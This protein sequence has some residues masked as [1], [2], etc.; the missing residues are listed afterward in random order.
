[1]T[2]TPGTRLGPYEVLS[3]L[4]AGGMGEVWKAKDTRL[5]RFVAIKVLP[6][7]LAKHPESLAR[8]EREAKAVAALNHPNILALHDIGRTDDTAY[9]VME[10]LEG[11]NLRDRLT[12]GPLPPRKATELAVQMA[13]G[14]AAAHE[15]GIVHRDL[16]PENLWVTRDGRLKIL[17]FGL[18]KQGPVLV[19]GGQTETPTQDF[20]HATEGGTVLGTVGYMSPEQVRGEAADNRSDIFSFGVVLFE[21]LGGARP[22]K[23]DT[24]VQTM[25]AILEDDPPELKLAKGRLPPMLGRIIQHCLEKAPSERF[26]SARDLAFDL[27]AAMVTD[28]ASVPPLVKP[29]ILGIT[30]PRLSV[31]ICFCALLGTGAWWM[32]RSNAATPVIKRLT[33]GKGTLGAARFVPGSRDVVYSARWNGA[34]PELFSLNPESLE[35]RTLG[36]KRASLVGISPSGE[37]AVKRNPR[38]WGGLELGQLVRVSPGGAE[39]IE[40][41]EILDADWMPDGSSL[42]E[43]YSF[44][45]DFGKAAIDFHRSHLAE[46]QGR[47]A[48]A[49]RV[50]PGGDWLALFEGPTYA[51]G[52]GRILLVDRAGSRKIL[53]E[54]SGFRGLAWGPNGKEIWYSLYKNGSS[55]LWS[56]PLD[57]RKRLLLRQA[58]LLELKDVASDG[59]VLA[60]LAL[61]LSGTT[62]LAGPNATEQD[63]SWNDAT[64]TFDVSDDGSKQV[65]GSGSVW[66]SE[67]NRKSLYLRELDHPVPV[68]IGIGVLARFIQ[69]GQQIMALSSLKDP[70]YSV[71]PVGFGQAREVLRVAGGLFADAS[72]FPDG[73]KVIANT[74][75]GWM[76]FDLPSATPRPFVGSEFLGINGFKPISP[77][78]KYVALVRSASYR[79]QFSIMII[80]LEGGEAKALKGL[81]PGDVPVRWDGDGHAIYVF[82]RDGLPAKLHRIE[83]ATGKRTLVRTIMPVNP[84]GLAGIRTLAIT[85]DARFVAYNYTRKLSDLYLIEGLK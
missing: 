31:V 32:G 7:H 75:E 39:R 18:A 22:F 60:S 33:F 5:D 28:S 82:N 36:I 27:A 41:E 15:K 8:F 37:Y 1:M 66:A 53:A 20:R 4:G 80:P 26:Q 12:T 16:K 49:V 58:G 24:P 42:A 54:L 2:L 77:D 61:E 11:E 50:S 70:V 73:R 81:E 34:D 46:S 64:E 78:G 29:G 79:L 72:P 43:V 52:D 21:M 14:I 23:G 35:P 13:Q 84:A 59:R 62:G 47:Q 38:L 30:G 45:P 63:L 57:G 44:S 9:A 71:I 74:Q 67:V 85:P 68:K 19:S 69:G 6:E 65:I 76:I 40:L 10:L 51:F 3:P 25:S 83:I 17:D 56:L 48:W 55:E